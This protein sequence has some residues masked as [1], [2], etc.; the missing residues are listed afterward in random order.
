MSEV[1][2]YIRRNLTID[3]QLKELIHV[4]RKWLELPP[5]LIHSE[6]RTLRAYVGGAAA[7]LM[8]TLDRTLADQTFSG[9]PNRPAYVKLSRMLA[10]GKAYGYPDGMTEKTVV[11]LARYAKDIHIDSGPAWQEFCR[12]KD[13]WR[14][15]NP[16]DRRSDWDLIKLYGE[17]SAVEPGN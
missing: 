17:G 11:R 4:G 12:W 1:D 15:E 10:R 7:E 8:R 9:S 14:S 3:G 6:G 5:F 13:S 16:Q 2:R